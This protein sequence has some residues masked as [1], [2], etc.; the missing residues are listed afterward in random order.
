MN[1]LQKKTVSGVAGLALVAL[2]LTSTVVSRTHGGDVKSQQTQRQSSAIDEADSLDLIYTKQMAPASQLPGR[3]VQLEKAFR[4]AETKAA[5]RD[6][7]ELIL[8]VARGAEG[9]GAA[10]AMTNYAA[11]R[12]L[13]DVED[14]L[15]ARELFRTVGEGVVGN[16]LSPKN[17]VDAWRMAG[18]IDIMWGKNPRSALEAYN[19]AIGLFEASDEDEVRPVQKQYLMSL[20]FSGWALR[21][22]GD[23]E[24]SIARREKALAYPGSSWLLNDVERKNQLMEIARAKARVN[25]GQEAYD[26]YE[27]VLRAFPSIAEDGDIYYFRYEQLGA[28]GLAESAVEYTTRLKELWLDPSLKEHG[29][30]RCRVGHKLASI[31]RRGDDRD[32]YRETLRTLIEQLGGVFAS[33]DRETLREHSL[34]HIY[35]LSIAELARAEME[36]GFIGPA[37]DLYERFLRLFPDHSMAETID[38]RIVRLEEKLASK[39]EVGE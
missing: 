32:A 17:A 6:I 36:R 39:A 15:K 23:D 30:Q 10:S 24:A 19:R 11:Y 13:Y 5:K 18:Q 25:P 1:S 37:I 12:Y 31:I 22:L 29:I 20:T 3:F 34:E 38:R 2:A 14:W 7:L 4:D 9:A 28:L 26:A 35:A 8:A 21:D 27:R 16:E 33:Q